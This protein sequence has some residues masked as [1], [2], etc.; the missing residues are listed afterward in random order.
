MK[1]VGLFA[2]K[3][4]LSAL[5]EAARHGEE[6]VISVRGVPAARL[7]PIAGSPG[8]EDVISRLLGNATPMGMSIREA[9]EEGRT[10]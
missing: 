5:V 4:H 8:E 7:V 2:A 9:I 1:C 10:G 6:T 3:T